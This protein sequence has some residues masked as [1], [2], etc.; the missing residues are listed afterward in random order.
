MSRKRFGFACEKCWTMQAAP[1]LCVACRPA[2][3]DVDTGTECGAESRLQLSD[4][5][6]DCSELGGAIAAVRSVT[7]EVEALCPPPCGVVAAIDTDVA[8]IGVGNDDRN[9]DTD[10][11]VG[12]D[13]L[14]SGKA[15]GAEQISE[16]SVH[17]DDQRIECLGGTVLAGVQNEAVGVIVDG[18]V[19]FADLN[20]MP[21]ERPECA[22]AVAHDFSLLEKSDDVEL[23]GCDAIASVALGDLPLAERGGEAGVVVR[24]AGV[25]LDV[26]TSDTRPIDAR[27][28]G[29]PQHFYES[30][31]LERITQ[32]SPLGFTADASQQFA[33]SPEDRTAPV[34]GV[35]VVRRSAKKGD[36]A[37]LAL[38]PGNSTCNNETVSPVVDGDECIVA[39]EELDECV[40]T[41]H[42]LPLSEAFGAISPHTLSSVEIE[43]GNVGEGGSVIPLVD[44]QTDIGLSEVI[45]EVRLQVEKCD[46]VHDSSTPVGGK[47]VRAVDCISN[48]DSAEDAVCNHVKGRAIQVAHRGFGLREKLLGVRHEPIIR[49]SGAN[50]KG[51][52]AEDSGNVNRTSDHLVGEIGQSLLE[53][54]GSA[55]ELDESRVERDH[56]GVNFGLGAHSAISVSTEVGSVSTEVRTDAAKLVLIGSDG[57]GSLHAVDVCVGELRA[58]VN[59]IEERNPKQIFADHLADLQSTV[60]RMKDGST[61]ADNKIGVVNVLDRGVGSRIGVGENRVEVVEA[62]GIGHLLAGRV[63]HIGDGAVEPLDGMQRGLA[64]QRTRVG[65]VLG[66][67]SVDEIHQRLDLQGVQIDAGDGEGVRVAVKDEIGHGVM[68]PQ[69]IDGVKSDRSSLTPKQARKLVRRL[70]ARR[71][72]GS[73]REFVFGA[74][75]VLESSELD[76]NWHHDALCFHFQAMIEDWL[77]SGLPAKEVGAR[78]EAV[79][80]ERAWIESPDAQ[81]AT[82]YDQLLLDDA[83]AMKRHWIE[84]GKGVYRQR[85]TDLAINVGPVSLKSRLITVFGPAWVWLLKPDWKVFCTG[86]TP[87][88]VDGCSMACRD[89]VVSEWYRDN[90][91]LRWTVEDGPVETGIADVRDDMDKIKRWGTTAGGERVSQGQLAAVTG[92]HV[93]AIISDDPDDAKGVWSA[94]ERRD[95]WNAW[96]AMGNRL[97]DMRRPLRMIVQQNLHDEDL[98]SKTVR[99]GMPRLA[100]PIVW[101]ENR[102]AECY[103]APFGWRDPRTEDGALSHPARFPPEVLV[104][105]R[106]RL[107]SHGFAAQYDC[108]TS[109]LD[110]GMFQRR[111]FRFFQIDGDPANANPRPRPGGCVGSGVVSGIDYGTIAQYPAFLLKKRKEHY[112]HDIPWLQV[113]AVLDL[114]WLTISVD[115]TFGSLADSASAVGLLAVAGKAQ[116][117]FVLDDT[118]EPR[119]FPQTITA[120]KSL[121]RKWPAKRVLIEK[122]ANGAAVISQL[123]EAMAENGIIGPDGKPVTV[124][125]EAIEPEGGKQSRAAALM[126]PVEAGMVYLLEGAPWLD[127]FLGELCTFPNSKRDDR[128]DALSQLI[129][130][131]QDGDIKSKWSRMASAATKVVARKPTHAERFPPRG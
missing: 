96:L 27:V 128:V 102:R 45:S 33:H 71:M 90:F 105:E 72:R 11:V 59:R 107:G 39:S 30:E 41:C 15:S 19:V 12:H 114:D 81:G 99:A 44:V 120:I 31:F 100:I 24:L 126:G 49:P 88:V 65:V 110:G 74:W 93:D 124:V 98:T 103:T 52:I 25:R 104:R 58:S 62:D 10:I 84:G 46:V 28:D 61:Q 55:L 95:V 35:R 109:A 42:D 16:H 111:W 67:S 23:V 82:P 40:V 118:T 76:W 80:A 129:T 47:S 92:L 1:G 57:I 51:S 106:T 36:E 130:Y 14:T 38:P 17:S 75:H 89:L 113:P 83:R 13:L 119:T 77:L 3:D 112:N 117:R 34:V 63:E 116:M 8:S 26:H 68:L 73:L 37:A 85:T 43:L 18:S 9:K 125:L 91:S 131:Y 6:V 79:E 115:A 122:K 70:R 29:Q 78:L 2:V 53:I 94:S 50:V 4:E 7:V 54:D 21:V 66:A 60:P 32:K 5:I 121:I 97:N 127:A 48:P 64:V 101:S 56:G 20:G 86:G 22:V 69:L 108:S 87:A 123:E